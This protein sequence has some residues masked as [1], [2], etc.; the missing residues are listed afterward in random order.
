[1]TPSLS[2]QGLQEPQ[3]RI[4]PFKGGF[5]GYTEC[6]SEDELATARKGAENASVKH[7][8]FIR[9]KDETTVNLA[10]QDDE[11]KANSEEFRKD[12]M[13]C[14]HDM[15]EADANALASDAARAD[16][17]TMFKEL[18]RVKK[19]DDNTLD[20]LLT[21][22]DFV[23]DLLSAAATEQLEKLAPGI[24]LDAVRFHEMSFTGEWYLM[25]EHDM[26]VSHYNDLSWLRHPLIQ[27]IHHQGLPQ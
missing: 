5:R 22:N 26:D 15:A 12:L 2:E 11:A 25:E 6:R 24:D 13:L 1:M 10:Q 19:L 9:K 16:L 3:N 23:S 21:D 27:P 18:E 7:F 17:A 20:E 4:R 8:G 14:Y